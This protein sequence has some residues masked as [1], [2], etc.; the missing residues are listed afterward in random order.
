MEWIDCRCS[1][2]WHY[3]SWSPTLHSAMFRW[4]SWKPFGYWSSHISTKSQ[5]CKVCTILKKLILPFCVIIGRNLLIMNLAVSD[6]WQCL[7]TMPITFTEIKYR[8]DQG[9]HSISTY[10]TI[11]CFPCSF[12]TWY[13]VSA[14]CK[15]MPLLASVSV[16]VSTLSIT[17]ITL[18]RCVTST[19]C[20]YLIN[21]RKI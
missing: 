14:L 7:V 8:W 18:D 17:A 4:N 13:P 2:K 16:F 20:V 12:W 15:T 21:K 19:L 5:K 1:G 3:W 10:S 9:C 11:K 6:L